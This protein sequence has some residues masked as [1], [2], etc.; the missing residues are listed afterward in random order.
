M[1]DDSFNDPPVGYV[2]DD[3]YYCTR[4]VDTSL[5]TDSSLT[6]IYDDG[7]GACAIVCAACGRPFVEPEPADG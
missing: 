3:H 1:R 4:C 7:D 6:P 2:I 5:P